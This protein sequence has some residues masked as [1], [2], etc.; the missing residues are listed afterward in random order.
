VVEAQSG[1][2]GIQDEGVGH[3]GGRIVQRATTSK[4]GEQSLLCEFMEIM[5]EGKKQFM[6]DGYCKGFSLG[7]KTGHEQLQKPAEVGGVASQ[8][9]AGQH[10]REPGAPDVCEVAA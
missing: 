10:R 9:I 3:V 5:R 4:F 8:V 6:L 7:E 2:I 1:T